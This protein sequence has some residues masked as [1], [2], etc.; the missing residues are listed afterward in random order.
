MIYL[1]KKEREISNTDDIPWRK[2]EGYEKVYEKI[3]SFDDETGAYTRLLK[4]DPG[5]EIPKVL[6]HD[7]WEEII[8]LDGILIDKRKNLTLTKGMY[9]CRPPGMKHGPYVSPTGC[10]TFEIRYYG[11]KGKEK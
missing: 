10:I 7:F 9:G 8:I 4:F 3:L 2:V 11:L 6:E 1:A 5:A